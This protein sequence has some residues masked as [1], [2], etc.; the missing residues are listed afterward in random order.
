MSEQRT[1]GMIA[2]GIM[3]GCLGHH[4]DCWPEGMAM[5][6]TLA[7]ERER[8]RCTRLEQALRSIVDQLSPLVAAGSACTDC[9]NEMDGAINEALTALENR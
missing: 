6:I 8:A 7:L 3:A 1:P 9:I 4:N 2:Y 5:Q